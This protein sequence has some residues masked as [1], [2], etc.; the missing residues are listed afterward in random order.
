LAASVDSTRQ[1]CFELLVNL[2]KKPLV[3]DVVARRLARAPATVRGLRRS[4]LY[5]T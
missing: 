2:L 5:L 4:G 1:D 3:R